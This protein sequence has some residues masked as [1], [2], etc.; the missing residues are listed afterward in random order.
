[1]VLGY[2]CP[3]CWRLMQTTPCIHATKLHVRS[4]VDPNAILGVLEDI[5][6]KLAIAPGPLAVEHIDGTTNTVDLEL[7][8]TCDPHIFELCIRATQPIEF[9]QTVRGFSS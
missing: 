1:M 5:P 6:A 7:A 8:R 2:P 4:S 9:W 3:E